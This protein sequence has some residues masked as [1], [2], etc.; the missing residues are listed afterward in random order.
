KHFPEFVVGDLH[1]NSVKE[2]WK[3]EDYNK[4]RRTIQ[5]GN[6]PVCTKCNNLY[7]HGRKQEK[8]S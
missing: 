7:L 1:K 8:E 4:I 5:C 2:I 3:N 6:M